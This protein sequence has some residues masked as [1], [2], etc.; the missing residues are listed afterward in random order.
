MRKAL[1]GLWL[2]AALPALGATQ[3]VVQ[4]G[5]AVELSV[6]PVDSRE[7]ELREG[8]RAR[9]SLRFT[10]PTGAPLGGLYPAAWMDRLAAKEKDPEAC[11]KKTQGFLG[12]TFL[13]RPELDLNTYYVLAMND[14]A[15]ISVVDPLFG[16]GNSKLLAMVFLKSPGEDWALTPDGARLFVSLPGSDR[17]AVIET[18]DWTVVTEIETRRQPRRLKLQPDGDLLWVAREGGVSAVSTRALRV[19]ADISTGP[20]NH[21]MAVSLNSRHLFVAHEGTVSIVDTG[22][23]EKVADLPIGSGPL[24]IDWSEPAG[25]A[26]VAAA[27]G[28]IAA[29]RPGSPEPVAKVKAESGL[30]RLRFA[31]GGRLAFIPNPTKNTVHILDAARG[32]IVQTADVEPGPDQVT[33]SDELAY[34]RH[35]GSETVLMIPLKEVGVEGRIVPLVDFPGGQNPPGRSSMP[36]PADGIVQAPGAAAVLVANFEDKAIYYYKEGMAAPMGHFPA[37]GKRPRA[38]QVVDRSLR[39]TAP[40]VYETHI[41]LGR[42]G[43]YDVAVLVGTPK[44]LHC[45]PLTVAED[46]KAAE[47]RKRKP[48]NVEYL[49]DRQEVGV[50]E[51][52]AV[53]LRIT[54]PDSGGPKTGL[55]DVRVLTFLAPGQRQQ[56][57]V[58]SEVGDGVY[59]IRF[60]P[61][62]EGVWLVFLEVDSAGLPFQRSPSLTLQAVSRSSSR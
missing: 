38:V 33:F 17:I 26:W 14:D 40:G 41:Q 20:G 42:A 1:A 50:G 7:G 4:E 19:V 47:R 37:Y 58:A 27:D 61:A 6:A 15:T 24:S 43:S 11:R 2:L 46:P 48:L 21:D 62:K 30:G 39:E 60:R 34:V 10:D 54:D 32:R 13:S 44:V 36:T 9:V 3:K 8:R 22:K 25:A 18:S 49:V 45:F 16:Y 56:R 35:R 57:Q 55:K 53:R 12:G 29:I 5:I 51:E 31:P 28:T 23:L 59:E 52:V